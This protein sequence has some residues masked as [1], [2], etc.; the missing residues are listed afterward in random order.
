[1]SVEIRSP[2]TLKEWFGTVGAGVAVLTAIFGIYLHMHTD[3]EADQTKK[4]IISQHVADKEDLQ[5]QIIASQEMLTN[6]INRSEILRMRREIKR[7]KDRRSEPGRTIYQ[8][9]QDNA[10]I[11]Y[12]EDVIECIQAERTNCV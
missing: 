12:Y 3:L 4:V 7:I 5:K 9:T 8:I 2:N 6:S 10:D 1:M 11:E